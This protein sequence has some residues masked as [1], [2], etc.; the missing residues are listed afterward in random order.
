MGAIGVTIEDEGTL[1]RP[2][3]QVDRCTRH[4]T[5]SLDADPSLVGTDGWSSVATRRRAGKTE[6]RPGSPRGRPP[7]AARTPSKIWRPPGRCH[8]PLGTTIGRAWIPRGLGQV[9]CTKGTRPNRWSTCST[10]R[11]SATARHWIART[12]LRHDREPHVGGVRRTVDHGHLEFTSLP[13]PWNS[14]LPAPRITGAVEMTSSSTLRSARASASSRSSKNRKPLSALGGSVMRV[15]GNGL[16]PPRRWLSCTGRGRPRRRS[17]STPARRRAPCRGHASRSRGRLRRSTGRVPPSSGRRDRPGRGRQLIAAA[18]DRA[19]PRDSRGRD[20]LRGHLRAS[21]EVAAHP[22]GGERNIRMATIPM[23]A[24]LLSGNRGAASRRKHA[25]PDRALMPMSARVLTPGRATNARH[26]RGQEAMET[27]LLARSAR[28]HPGQL[29]WMVL[30]TT[31]AAL[32]RH[33]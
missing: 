24:T 9:A 5:A 13:N 8:H 11:A 25:G 3:Q 16:V 32:Y 15:P 19:H 21:T 31:S 17:P 22:Q 23:V 26:R 1:G 27:R 30:W 7:V 28:T 18:R 29:S 12:A 6:A 33:P 10:S 20:P 2:D 4:P 14:R